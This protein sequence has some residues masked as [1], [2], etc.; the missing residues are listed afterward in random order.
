MYRQI[1]VND[2]KKTFQREECLTFAEALKLYT[3]NAAYVCGMEK[4]LG[5][6]IVHIFKI[7]S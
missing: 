1:D 4:Q 6:I 2:K 3:L 5:F 7:H